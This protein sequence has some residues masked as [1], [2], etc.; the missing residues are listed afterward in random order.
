M[1][2]LRMKQPPIGFAALHRFAAV[3]FRIDF[4]GPPEARREN[5]LTAK[6]RCLGAVA[7]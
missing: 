7:A 2:S 3:C 1:R 4:L 5:G 6:T